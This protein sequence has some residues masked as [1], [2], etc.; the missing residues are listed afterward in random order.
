MDNIRKH[1][2]LNGEWEFMPIYGVE[3]SLEMQ[4]EFVAEEQ[5]VKVPSSYRYTTRGNYIGVI[6]DYELYNVY[7]YP[8]RW[9]DAET[10][11]LRREFTLPERYIGKRIFLYF[12]AILQMSAIYLNDEK[13]AVSEQGFLPIE[14]EITDI[15]KSINELK[16]LVTSFDST[17][18]PSGQKKSIGING[19]WHGN[20]S[21]GIW[22]NCFLIARP[23]IYIG[24]VNVITSVQ[25]KEITF[26]LDVDNYDVEFTANNISFGRKKIINNAVTYKWENPILWDIENPYLYDIEI[27][28]FDGENLLDIYT[29]KIGFREFTIDGHKFLLN[30]TRI[31][32]RGDS[33][34]Y[35]GSVQETKEYALNWFK[36]CRQNG[37]NIVRLHA[38]PHPECYLDAADEIGMLIMDETGI[39][40]SGKSMDASNSVYIE[41]CRDFVRRLVLRD[42]NHPSV[43]IW[44]LQNEM[45]WVD[46]R[47]EF[48]KY[49]VELKNIFHK[50]DGTRPVILEGDNR[51][52]SKED[53]EIESMHYNID[54]TIEQWDMKKPLIF[55]EHGGIWYICPQ[56]SSLYI[57]LSAYDSF[58]EC[59]KGMSIK[60]KLFAE[61]AR[62]K[63]VSGISTF[64]F[65]NYFNYS[66]PNED[67][68]TDKM[69]IPKYSLT[70][71]NGMLKDYP[72]NIPNPAMEIV[73]EGFKAVTI[74]PNEYDT[75]FYAGKIKRSFN[76][77]NETMKQRNVKINTSN[78]EH[79]KF[80]QEPGELQT[81][82]I[83]LELYKDTTFKINDLSIDYRIINLELINKKFAFFGSDKDFK[84]I[85]GIAP[86]AVK[87]NNFTELGSYRVLVLGSC[88]ESIDN[89]IEK[90]INNGGRVA[91][92]EQFNQSLGDMQ[93]VKK[94]F[95]SAF[96]S[97][98]THP[99]LKDLKSDDFIYWGG[100]IVEDRPQ[101][102]I[103]QCFVKPVFGDFTIVLESCMGDYGDGGDL[104]SPLIE[105]RHNN[106]LIIFNQIE[107]MNNIKT[108]P[109]AAI[110]LRNIIERLD[111][112]VLSTKY[113]VVVVDIEEI[114]S[115]DFVRNGGNVLILPTT[116][117][118]KLSLLL[119]TEV[120]IN[121]VPTYHIKSNEHEITQGISKVDLF[122][123]EK[124]NFSPRQVENIP[125]AFNSIEIENA[126][127]LFTSITGTPWYDY[128]VRGIDD[129]F[130]RIALVSINKDKKVKELPY[131]VEYTLEKGKVYIS[132]LSYDL[133][134]EKNNRI[135]S[136]LISNLGGEIK[137]NLF[138]Y[139]KS[140]KDYAVECMMTL[141]HPDY[142]DYNEGVE[143]YTDKGYSLN[144]LGEGLYGWMRKV[145]KSSE[146]FITLQDSADNGI[147]FMTCFVHSI[148]GE[149]D[150]KL[151]MTANCETKIWINGENLVEKFKLNEGLNRLV[152][153][154]VAGSENI[155]IRPIFMNVDGSFAN[156]LK[157]TL[158]IDEQG[159]II[160][161]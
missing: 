46:G 69:K 55:G 86:N 103:E 31:N 97:D 94:D 101:N 88:L 154:A 59:I 149:I 27:K 35:Q 8:D 104:W 99:L 90:F 18:V 62:S 61:Y 115:L 141:P 12:G 92:L 142:L 114:D 87:L 148:G 105:Y 129:E 118:G 79:F 130:C 54:G 25:K 71:N 50:Y 2:T 16:V 122:R 100:K 139:I 17:I 112:A 9:N 132:Q 120:K 123:F 1:M 144:N 83:E 125:I 72:L 136:K 21:R 44:S 95:F 93:L 121:P 143:Y 131:L 159:M 30:G 28:L 82:E 138:T 64:N 5:K 96:A 14:V 152:I 70:V 39:H 52:I 158:T 77:Y 145:E 111:S 146:G 15:I 40:G 49:E 119:E 43:V 45:R 127:S 58:E 42:K 37:V 19:S 26:K 134:N 150:A 22:Q 80:V 41:R 135:Y 89:S 102:I 76:I 51:I 68:Q 57:G 116:N 67:V 85:K 56:N 91:I 6:D 160:I 10:G 74:I 155:S 73:S 78:G 107:I 7:G 109:Q 66:M 11:I 47:N 106:G 34:H 84:I 133:I 117:A 153:C 110:L 157:Y 3:S 137:D 108:V 60:E 147:Y 75:V 98:Q 20:I 113:D 161:V 33:W 140:E 48:K 24:N 63:E 13:I 156:N 36:L 38:Q 29:D 23:Q 126:K 65:A 53:T 32:L 81:I 151:D 4:K 128:Y 124:V